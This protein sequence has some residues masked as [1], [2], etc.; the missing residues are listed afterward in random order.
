MKKLAALLLLTTL[1]FTGCGKNAG[2]ASIN[3]KDIAEKTV[4]AGGFTDE[5][6]ALTDTTLPASYTTLDLDKVAEYAVHVSGTMGTPEEVAVI[7]A[8]SEADLPDVKAAVERR[9]EDLKL[10]FEDY[11]PEE[12]P[13]IESA[14]LITRGDCVLLAVAPDAAAAKAALEG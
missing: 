9:L 14:V 6:V 5:L 11:R 7:R 4:A 10:N 3:V 2:G 13:K 12:M 8:K 1:L